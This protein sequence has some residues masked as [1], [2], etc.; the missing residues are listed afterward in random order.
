MRY[1]NPYVV[2]DR[3]VLIIPTLE[4]LPPTQIEEFENPPSLLKPIVYIGSALLLF[5]YLT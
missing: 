4:E 5:N 2:Q 1:N 3:G